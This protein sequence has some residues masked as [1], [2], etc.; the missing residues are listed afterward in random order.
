MPENKSKHVLP[1]QAGSNVGSDLSMEGRSFAARSSQTAK[2]RVTMRRRLASIR[3]GTRRRKYQRMATGDRRL[4]DLNGPNSERSVA[5][6]REK[7]SMTV[8]VNP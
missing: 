3:V 8:E 5:G 2:S 4:L 7:Q 1:R 6:R